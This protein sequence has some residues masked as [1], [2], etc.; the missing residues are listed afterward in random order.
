MDPAKTLQFLESSW[1]STAIGW[2][3][4][5]AAQYR[6]ARPNPRCIVDVGANLGVHLAHFVEMGCPRILAFEPIPELA[7]R[8]AGLYASGPVTVHQLA[9]G[10][11]SRE[12][13]F[14]VDRDVLAESGLKCRVDRPE[15]SREQ[16]S[17]KVRPLDSFDLVD[18]D[19]LKID[20]EGAEILI[21]TGADAT[22]AR[23]RPLVS[24][25]YGWAGYHTYG[26]QKR[27][28]LDWAL[29]HDYSITDLF[30][31]LITPEV[32]D[33][34]VDRYYW[35]YLLVPVENRELSRRLE[36]KGEALLGDFRSYIVG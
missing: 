18:L 36:S 19:Y 16:L 31:G 12:A 26:L 22:I 34:C 11:A 9:L 29:R 1:H 23:C 35:D 4:I 21:L 20:A 33:A 32:Y 30:G 6:A 24:V 5:L 27:A 2:E 7:S 28:L 10:E 15:R 13:T 3:G 25:E 14:Y 17:V 8:L